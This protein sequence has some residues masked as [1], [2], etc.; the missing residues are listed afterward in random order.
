[1]ETVIVGWPAGRIERMAYDRLVQRAPSSAIGSPRSISTPSGS[2]AM[3]PAERAAHHE[4]QPLVTELVAEHAAAVQRAE[5]LAFLY[6]TTAGVLP[7]VVKGWLERWMV[8]GVAFVFDERTNRVRPGLR[9]IRRIVGVATYPGGRASRWIGGDG[10]RRIILRALRLNT[11]LRT[12]TD[13]L[14][15]HHRDTV[16]DAERDAFLNSI[17]AAAASW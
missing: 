14:G 3:T 1:M 5:V 12:S 8:P 11:G 13:W 4:A 7:A 16:G 17:D 2:P 9:N 15:L 10:G 6:P